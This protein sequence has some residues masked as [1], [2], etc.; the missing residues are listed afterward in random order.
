MKNF[1]WRAG[2]RALFDDFEAPVRI[3]AC[4]EEQAWVIHENADMPLACLTDLDSLHSPDETDGA[5]VGALLAA[6][7]EAWKCD[8]YRRLTID[9]AG[10]GFWVVLRNG[11]HRPPSRARAGW[12]LDPVL[13]PRYMNVPRPLADKYPSEWAA[14][15]A[16]WEAAPT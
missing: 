13:H 1:P 4:D 2:M 9:L 3:L 10:D 11:W 8:D 15:M 16:A 6:V 12:I 14:L 7:R 5:T